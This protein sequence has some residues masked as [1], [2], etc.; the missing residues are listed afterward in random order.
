ME[1]K[2]I[3]VLTVFKVLNTISIKDCIKSKLEEIKNFYIKRFLYEQIKIR[4]IIK[5]F[6]R[7]IFLNNIIL[8]KI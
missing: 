8:Y 7:R 2:F 1:Y 6:V 4:V 3:G 5:I